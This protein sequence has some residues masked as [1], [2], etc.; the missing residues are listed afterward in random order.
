M[1]ELEVPIKITQEL[2]LSKHPAE[3]YMEFYLE[4]P[5]KKGLFTSPSWL[6]KDNKPTCA[7]YKDKK[8]SLIF[9][10]FAGISGNFVNIVMIKY[11]C[12]YYKALKIIANDFGIIET[13]LPKN[14]AIAPYSGFELKET[15]KA[16]IQVELQDFSKKELSWWS[17]FGV[18]PSS[19][20]KFKVFSVKSVF[21]NG[22]YFMSSST[23]TPIYGYYGGKDVDDNE[24]WR[25]YMPTKIKYRFLSNWPSSLIQGAKQLPKSGEFVVIT[26]SLKD[27]MALDTFEIIAIAPNSENLFLS[28]AQY[29]KLQSKFN[30][31]YLLYDFDR[32]G[33]KAAKKIKK[34]FPNIQVLLI[35]KKYRCKDFSD[36][37]KKYGLTKTMELVNTFKKYYLCQ[38][39]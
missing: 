13:N 26:K 33:I 15:T 20:K 35:P 32:L 2:L 27:V 10:D 11:N 24:L 16:K 25:L 30:K 38:K 18:S 23:S 3:A 5:V 1:Y 34:N 6:R 12:S 7:F 8:G 37:I 36:F 29:E 19:L 17:T 28:E 21:L 39:E 31:I 4:L 14:V 22:Q 9:K